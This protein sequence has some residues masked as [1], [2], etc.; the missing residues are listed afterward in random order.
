VV[1]YLFIGPLVA[2]LL[3]WLF[4]RTR[5]ILYPVLLLHTA[6]NNSQRLL[7]TTTLF[8][9]LLTGVIVAIIIIDRMWKHRAAPEPLGSSP[10]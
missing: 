3:T 4:N 6:I 2:I 5:G 7:P 10:T 1:E 9:V 8:P